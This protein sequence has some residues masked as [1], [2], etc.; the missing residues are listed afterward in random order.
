MQIEAI[1]RTNKTLGVDANLCLPTAEEYEAERKM[2]LQMHSN[3]S[4]FTLTIL[5]GGIGTKANI[6]ASDIDLI[7][8]ETRLGLEKILDYEL[9]KPSEKK[10]SVAYTQKLFDKKFSGK[11][12]AE[13]LLEDPSKKEEL[14]KTRKFLEANISK[15]K[16]NQY[17]INAI[18]DAITLF[19]KGELDADG[20]VNS[21]STAFFSIYDE[22]TKIPNANKTD[23]KG[24]TFVYSISIKCAPDKDYP[25]I[26][27]IMN[28][29]APVK[30]DS[31]GRIVAELSKIE[32][33]QKN[34][35]LLTKKEWVKLSRKMQKT[36]ENFE[37]MYFEKQYRLAQKNS[38]HHD[39]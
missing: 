15:Y 37:S 4:R 21:A 20:T 25:F 36:V 23:K 34:S 19:E 35:F 32:D 14:L 27:N 3:Y 39:K 31:T 2:P 8:E 26:I 24:N 12:P 7:C 13:V 6:P 29:M 30:K 33:E 22:P 1:K 9:N 17:Q 18:D 5:E 16:A 28:G 11:T 38:Y 10:R